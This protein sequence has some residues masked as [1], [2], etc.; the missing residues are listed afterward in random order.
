M[1]DVL[2]IITEE[3]DI[4][5]EDSSAQVHLIADTLV[6]TVKDLRFGYYD[7]WNLPEKD[8]HIHTWIRDYR[9]D[10]LWV[11]IE[12]R[13]WYNIDLYYRESRNPNWRDLDYFKKDEL[14]YGEEL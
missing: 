5:P 13:V 1:V 3:F 8:L 7:M 4:K 12:F 10:G 2:R 9:S 14:D 11:S 6:L